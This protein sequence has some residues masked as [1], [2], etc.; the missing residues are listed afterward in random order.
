MKMLPDTYSLKDCIEVLWHELQENEVPIGDS[1]K[2]AMESLENL[3][4]DLH[5]SR[6]A[7]EFYDRVSSLSDHRD[8]LR[9]HING[10]IETTREISKMVKYDK[11]K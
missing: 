3:D 10:L 7:I 11:A 4:I 6:K 5:K 9:V 1:L 8:H 2:T